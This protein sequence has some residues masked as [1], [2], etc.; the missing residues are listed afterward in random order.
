MQILYLFLLENIIIDVLIIILME[1]QHTYSPAFLTLLVGSIR[2]AQFSAGLN[3]LFLLRTLQGHSAIRWVGI[4]HH[5]YS[6]ISF[7]IYYR[8]LCIESGILKVCIDRKLFIFTGLM[9][10]FQWNFI[11]I[12]AFLNIQ[13]MAFYL[14]DQIFSI[15]LIDNQKF[16]LIA[17]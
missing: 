9:S 11:L 2:V 14:G 17:Y 4:L 6:R 15:W 3:R 13:N 16:C 10:F 1:I 12:K 8:L 7:T 5:T